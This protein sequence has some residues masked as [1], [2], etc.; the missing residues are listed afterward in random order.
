VTPGGEVVVLESG[1]YGGGTI[2]KSVTIHAP[3]GVVA[4]VAT[5]IVVSA[6]ASDV[7][8]LRGITIVAPTPG[9]GDALTFEAGAGLNVERCVIHGWYSGIVVGTSGK[10]SVTDTTVRDS[11]AAGIYLYAP[12]GALEASLERTRLLGNHYGLFVDSRA[13]VSLKWS[14]AAGNEF[15][16]VATSGDTAASELTIEE[17]VLSNNN[18]YGAAAFSGMSGGVG[19]VRISDS[20]VTNNNRGLVQQPSGVLLSRGNNTVEANKTSDTLGTIGAF[21]VK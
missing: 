15:G 20:V 14:I 9:S 19:T 11:G 8:T 12:A 10:L 7:V 2:A 1:T 3:E 13:R 17:C 18:S 16:V 6:G 21:G 5:P 4:L